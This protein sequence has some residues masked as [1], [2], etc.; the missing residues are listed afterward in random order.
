MRSPPEELRVL[1]PVWGSRYVK[2]FLEFCVPSLLAP[3]NIPSLSRDIACRFVCFT[4]A[5]DAEV[6]RADAA[7]QALAAAC[8]VEVVA[9]DDLLSDSHSTTITLA[10]LRGL[11]ACAGRLRDTCFIFLV[12]D[13]VVADGALLE[14]YTPIAAG[15][16]GVL[17]GNLQISSETAGPI[18]ARTRGDRLALSVQPR[19][20]V[21]IALDHMHP[22]TMANFVG[23]DAGPD[24]ASNRLLWRA[25]ETTLI[26]R[27]YLL[28]MLAIRPEV[29]AFVVAAPSDYSLIPELC[30]SGNVEIIDDSDRYCVVEMQPRGQG[31]PPE[32]TKKGRPAA[33]AAALASWATARHRQ[34]ARHALVF[35]CGDAGP[36]VDAVRRSSAAFVETIERLLPARAQPFRYHPYW[37]GAIN[38][39]QRTSQTIVDLAELCRLMGDPA[40]AAVIGSSRSERLRR[41]LLGQSP[42]LR[43]WHPR[44]LDVLG[45]WRF[46]R[47][48]FAGRAVVIIGALPAPVR[49]RL[50]VEGTRHGA[51]AVRCAA[52]EDV[53]AFVGQ[54]SAG[55]ASAKS[56]DACIILRENDPNTDILDTI[57]QWSGLPPADCRFLFVIGD[58]FGERVRLLDATML[59]RLI[60]NLP[61]GF[62]VEPLRLVRVDHGRALVQNKFMS[63]ARSVVAH[64]SPRGFADMIGA[65]AL[66]AASLVYNI[67]GLL[68]AGGP[69][70]G[71]ADA[72]FKRIP[73][74]APC[75]LWRC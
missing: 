17:A 23:P 6:I 19:A 53:G 50:V 54:R 36:A 61:G 44:W 60:V 69:P 25:G 3:G 33:I 40:F 64:R 43:P 13:Y 8:P 52:F 15:V 51:T 18:L 27:F 37:I 56:F 26:G 49:D 2:Q 20:L 38:H 73:D 11:R 62:D 58:V 16:S 34:N 1:L 48:Q 68:V 57:P 55:P 59:H 28:H 63:L 65:A 46:F 47:R 72:P 70:G 75:R 29:E 31:S 12:S 66:C 32:S 45:F 41:V 9:I 67:A 5:G 30:P 22:A 21:R 35:H 24:A 7:W 10:Y 39:H 42:M 74:V 4:R 14:A 71:A